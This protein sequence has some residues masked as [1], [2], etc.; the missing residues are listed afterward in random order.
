MAKKFKPNKKSLYFLYAVVAIGTLVVFVS[1]REKIDAP[2]PL[3]ESKP[4]LEMRL[5]NPNLPSST[6]PKV[7]SN[8]EAIDYVSDANLTSFWI[9]ARINFPVPK[10]MKYQ[11]VGVDSDNLIV[12]HGLNKT[13]G[14]EIMVIAR[15]LETRAHEIGPYLQESQLGKTGD[16]ELSPRD[17]PSAE[18]T[19][20]LPANTKLQP[21]KLWRFRGKTQ[22]RV[23]ALTN[24][25]DKAGSYVVLYTVP[26]GNINRTEE[27][28]VNLLKEAEAQ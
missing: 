27:F 16:K 8:K 5:G 28:L 6:K 17:F 24:R 1:M 12:L 18:R 14:T 23:A 7:P 20:A 9:A 19:V 4:N 25:K 2:A 13:E 21:A 10:A 11:K 22:D 3:P 15:N 26:R